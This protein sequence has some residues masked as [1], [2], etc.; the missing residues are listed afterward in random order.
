MLLLVITRAA[1]WSYYFLKLQR[2]QLGK[3]VLV[4]KL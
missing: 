1:K 2:F 4:E 3:L